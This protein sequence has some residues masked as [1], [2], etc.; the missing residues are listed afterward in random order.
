MANWYGGV[1]TSALMAAITAGCGHT[2]I[3]ESHLFQVQVPGQPTAYYRLNITGD[4]KLAKTHFRGGLY[5]AEA[6]SELLAGDRDADKSIRDSVYGRLEAERRQGI[7]EIAK[8]YY[9]AQADPS[10]SEDEVRRLGER[11]A[12][13]LRGDIATPGGKESIHGEKRYVII[14]SAIASVIEEALAS[15][16]EERDTQQLVVASMAGPQRTR[17]LRERVAAEEVDA[18]RAHVRALVDQLGGQGSRPTD[19]KEAKERDEKLKA[20]LQ[21]LGALEVG[22]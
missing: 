3:E 19:A 20:A 11:L 1:L 18:A 12:A 8:K 21:A 17:Y 7:T 14:F 22:P 10:R 13:A 2:K 5:D 15:F 6:V 4:A 16:A 9:A